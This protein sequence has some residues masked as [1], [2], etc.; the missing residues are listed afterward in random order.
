M[1]QIEAET[2]VGLRFAMGS[3]AVIAVCDP[4]AQP[5]PGASIASVFAKRVYRQGRRST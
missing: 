1:S 4:N 2:A 5:V 3:Q